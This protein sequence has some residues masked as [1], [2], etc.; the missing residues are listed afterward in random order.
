MACRVRPCLVLP[1][2]S[3]SSFLHQ[4]LDIGTL[5]RDY[6]DKPLACSPEELGEVTVEPVGDDEDKRLAMMTTWHPEARAP[7]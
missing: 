2:R 7:G 6:P 1:R 4:G 5:E 3:A